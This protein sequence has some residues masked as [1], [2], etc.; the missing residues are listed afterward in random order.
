[1]GG[2]W[3]D[4]SEHDREN[5]NCFEQMVYRNLDLED[6]ASGSSKGSKEHITG[7]WRKG[8]PCDNTAYTS[9]VENRMCTD[10]LGDIDKEISK[11]SS[12]FS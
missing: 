12:H 4:F 8:D 2:S 6:T 9:Y 10:V 1:M 7:N 11:L 5:L 3:K